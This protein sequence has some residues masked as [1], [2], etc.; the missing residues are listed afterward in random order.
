MLLSKTTSGWPISLVFRRKSEAMALFERKMSSS[1]LV[2]P[3]IIFDG[4]RMAAFLHEIV[5]RGREYDYEREAAGVYE[6]V[7][8]NI[9][10]FMRR[11][12]HRRSLASNVET[13]LWNRVTSTLAGLPLRPLKHRIP[14]FPL[15]AQNSFDV[16]FSTF[17]RS[18]IMKQVAVGAVGMIYAR[19]R[20]NVT[21][22]SGIVISRLRDRRWSAP[23]S[24]GMVISDANLFEIGS[25]EYVLFIYRPEIIDELRQSQRVDL[26]SYVSNSTTYNEECMV[27]IIAGKETAVVCFTKRDR[28]FFVLPTFSCQVFVRCQVNNRLYSSSQKECTMTSD[29]LIGKPASIYC[30]SFSNMPQSS[31]SPNR[32]TLQE[33][34]KRLLNVYAFTVH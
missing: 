17:W 25:N 22:G 30:R 7:R 3:N 2:L 26:S 23:C 29:I 28:S 10:S 4:S 11:P 34:R 5:T 33:K 32:T 8:G 14:L 31:T 27:D 24:I 9:E 6:I 15:D 20:S 18:Q 1:L 12:R 13:T 16:G 19:F 21:T